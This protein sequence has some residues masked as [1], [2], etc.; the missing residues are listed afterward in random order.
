MN[1]GPVID[2]WIKLFNIEVLR[3]LR[4][5]V[6]IRFIVEKTLSTS[7]LKCMIQYQILVGMQQPYM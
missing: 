5:G 4:I 2:I 6:L 3:R 1:D 7:A